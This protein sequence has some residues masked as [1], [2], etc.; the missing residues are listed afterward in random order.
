MHS[1]TYPLPFASRSCPTFQRLACQAE[2]R[3][4]LGLL[5]L[6]DP[7]EQRALSQMQGQAALG[8][9]W[10]AMWSLTRS[11]WLP[12]LDGAQEDKAPNLSSGRSQG[13]SRGGMATSSARLPVSS[14]LRRNI[15]SLCIWLSTDLWIQEIILSLSVAWLLDGV[16]TS[17]LL[18]QMETLK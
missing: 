10:G 9:P 11:T 2:S 13:V 7:F 6:W 4:S 5:G 15:P 12:H 3:A 14:A 8:E 18:C 16:A 1:L 17:P